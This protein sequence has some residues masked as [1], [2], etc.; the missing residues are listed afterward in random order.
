MARQNRGVAFPESWRL[1]ALYSSGTS[2]PRYV[3]SITR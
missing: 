3:T 2:R 1:S